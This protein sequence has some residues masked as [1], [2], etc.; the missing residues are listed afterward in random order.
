[1][2]FSNIYLLHW[3]FAQVLITTLQQSPNTHTHT[4]FWED[5][6][7]SNGFA[8]LIRCEW[9]LNLSQN[10]HSTFLGWPRKSSNPVP[11]DSGGANKKRDCFSNLLVIETLEGWSKFWVSLKFLQLLLASARKNAAT[12]CKEYLS[13]HIKASYLPR[14]NIILN[15]FLS[16][17]YN[18][19]TCSCFNLPHRLRSLVESNNFKLR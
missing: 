13:F 4:Y 6:G 1:M 5:L 18:F 11:C 3:C 2:L 14:D 7:W 10:W 12:Q 16:K 15:Q 17:K 19:L 8:C 9:F